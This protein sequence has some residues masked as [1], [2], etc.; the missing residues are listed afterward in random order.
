MDSSAS[1]AGGTGL[2]WATVRGEGQS[3]EYRERRAA[4]LDAGLRSPAV[5]VTDGAASRVGAAAAGQP[6][7]WQPLPVPLPTYVTKP[8]APRTSQSI[9]FSAPETWEAVRVVD[10]VPGAGAWDGG[11]R[12]TG[13]PNG[14]DGADEA[15]ARGPHADGPT[16]VEAADDPLDAILE[17]R[18][19]VGG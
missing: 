11:D 4:V 2:M 15:R 5:S 17:R 6:G 7:A 12:D 1:G 13:G 3:R 16:P 9:D 19:A 18:R 8:R 14:T 10:R